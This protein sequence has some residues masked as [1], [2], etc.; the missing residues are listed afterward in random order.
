MLALKNAAGF[1]WIK[2]MLEL[3]IPLQA[4]NEEITYFHFLVQ[5][6]ASEDKFQVLKSALL[7]KGMTVDEQILKDKLP[8]VLRV[9][10]PQPGLNFLHD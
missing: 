2:D 6:R 5:S 4:D 9:C 1:S 10:R 3:D 7:D 8:Q